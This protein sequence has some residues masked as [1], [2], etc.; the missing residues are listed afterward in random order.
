MP[1]SP[2]TFPTKYTPVQ[3]IGQADALFKKLIADLGRIYRL[4]LAD[5]QDNDKQRAAILSSIQTT[6]NSAISR[7]QIVS[8]LEESYMCRFLTGE[9]AVADATY[10]EPIRTAADLDRMRHNLSGNYRLMNNIDLTDATGTVGGD[11]YNSG[12]GWS[13]IG[14]VSTPF[15]GTFN[16][17]G[18]TITGLTI[19]RPT[20]G[21]CGLFGCL[22]P[23]AI[24][25]N[26]TLANADVTGLENVGPLCG[27]SFGYLYNCHAT[28]PTVEAVSGADADDVG[29][30]V[31]DNDGTMVLCTVTGGTVSGCYDVG[32]L[33]GD[34]DAVIMFCRSSADVD[35]AETGDIGGLAGDNK[36][37]K[38]NVPLSDRINRGIIYN[39]YATGNVT[40][41]NKLGRDPAGDIGGLVGD[42]KGG[43][44]VNCWATGN[45]TG[46]NPQMGGLAG[47][48]KNGDN[49][50][51]EIRKSQ[52]VN[53]Y[54][55]GNVTPSNDLPGE[56]AV[57][58][59]V[60]D[61]DGGQ[62]INSYCANTVT[63]GVGNNRN[64]K[65]AFAGDFDSETVGTG[66]YFDSTLAALGV[67][68]ELVATGKTTAEMMQ[69]A[70]FVQWD[71]DEVWSIKE[72]E[73]YP[74]LPDMEAT[75]EKDREP[76]Y[77]YPIARAGK[78]PL[79]GDVRPKLSAGDFVLACRG[80]DGVYY[81]PVMVEDANDIP[82]THLSWNVATGKIDATGGGGS[83]ASG[84]PLFIEAHTADDTLTEA[85][86]GSV[87]TNR[88]ATGV[89]VLTL[90]ASAAA[91]TQFTFAIQEAQQLRIDP[92]AAAIR[93]SAG[94]TAG[95]Y[96][97][98]D[99]IGDA[100]TLVADAAGDW[101]ATYKCGLWTEEP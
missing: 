35:G 87:H 59:L 32:G 28:N 98:A 86:S 64:K 26:V 38:E 76:V 50:L 29:G 78:N 34:N 52:I 5:I 47:D 44:L 25:K 75:E 40:S 30:L 70:T 22:G 69:K 94:Q 4:M 21:H 79:T 63:C 96:K 19:N 81:T 1:R 51:G 18:Y 39:S 23:G 91:G 6:T 90:P 31:G 36:G 49:L 14:S 88:G 11:Y 2:N 9:S 48:S 13:P 37:Y 56:G 7:M 97:W 100:I 73:G 84:G 89:V 67:S 101:V 3:T 58:G 61:I 99:N 65:N 77:V 74:T 45:V 83:G 27:E 80:A 95:K 46:L 62:V 10:Y 43:S 24:V 92:G 71:F 41:T 54:A 72:D 15:T 57:G 16:G 17:G 82:G 33:V 55:T 60:G 53:C 85:E 12:A 68:S 8:V 93:C 42:N 20:Q 66:C